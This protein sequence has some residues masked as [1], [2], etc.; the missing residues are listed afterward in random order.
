MR[1]LRKASVIVG[2]SL[3]LLFMGRG[4]LHLSPIQM[5]AAPYLYD[6]LTWEVSHFPDKWVYKLWSALPWNSKS[7]QERLEDLREFFQIGEEILDLE[8]ELSDMGVDSEHGRGNP[9]LAAGTDRSPQVATLMGELDELRSRRSDLK[10]GVEEILESEVSA[11]L[12]QE[13]LSS[14]IGVIFPPVDV[15][16]SNTPNVLVVSPRDRVERLETLLLK[17]D[18]KLEN[19]DIMEEKIFQEQGISALVLSI[20]GVATYPTIVK[21]GSSLRHTA[22]TA[23][24]EWLHAYWFFRPLGWNI[25]SGPDMTTL[26]ETAATLAGREMGNRVYESVTGQKVQEPPA[27]GSSLTDGALDTW[28]ARALGLERFDFGREMRKTRLKVDELLSQGKVEEA[29]AYMEERR[30]LFVENGFYIRK[31]NQAYFAFHGSYGDSPASVSPIG[32]EVDQLRKTTESVGDFI[33]TM[34]KFGSYQEFLEYVSRRSGPA[35]LERQS[36]EPAAAP[37]Q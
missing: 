36:G 20:G 31:L 9:G 12:A 2:L 22:V 29:E 19:M 15:A 1:R 17:S 6:L 35:A 8:R 10:P 13:G 21:Q 28:L 5:A 24:H 7:H 11:V 37:A 34:A 32:D 33:R 14:R 16:L 27:S 18:M 26:N 3:L 25:F 23:A 4:G 30:Q